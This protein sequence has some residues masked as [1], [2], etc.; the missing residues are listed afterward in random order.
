MGHIWTSIQI[1]G[2]E[3]SRRLCSNTTD[4]RLD[5]IRFSLLG[6]VYICRN[7]FICQQ[8]RN[9]NEQLNSSRRGWRSY[10]HKI[11]YANGVCGRESKT[12]MDSPYNINID[13]TNCYQ[14][15]IKLNWFRPSSWTKSR[16]NKIYYQRYEFCL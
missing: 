8:L 3:R 14:H 9:Q 10:V 13:Y 11:R 6:F 2:C 12:R 15:Q 7:S 5:K 4:C 1:R 16:W